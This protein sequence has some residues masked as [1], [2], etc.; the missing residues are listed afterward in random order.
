MWYGDEVVLGG[1]GGRHGLLW[2]VLGTLVLS[3]RTKE[4]SACWRPGKYAAA[5]CLDLWSARLSVGPTQHLYKN[6]QF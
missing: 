1:G 3:K 4:F 5:G 2:D 6:L